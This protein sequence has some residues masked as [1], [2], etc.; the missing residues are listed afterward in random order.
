MELRRKKDAAMMRLSPLLRSITLACSLLTLGV[1]VVNAWTL[2]MDWQRTVRSTEERAI[3][4]SVAQARQAEDTFLQIEL[5][6]REVQRVIQSQPG[7]DIDVAEVNNI[8]RTLQSRLPQLEDMF[9]FD[10]QGRWT[11][12]SLTEMPK[13]N[14]NAD[15]E[16]FIFHQHNLRSSVHVGPALRSRSSGRYVIPV[17]LRINDDYGGFKGVLL[18]TISIDYFRHYYDYFVIGP[19]DLLVLMLADST[20]LYARPLP[21]SYIGKNLSSSPLFHQ[22]L[23]NAERGSGQWKAELDGEK[24]IFGFVSSSRYPVVVTAGFDTKRLFL[25]WMQSRVQGVLLSLVLLV[26]IIL[27]WIFIRNEARRSLR[28]QLELTHLRDELT[29]ANQSLK[30]LA[31]ADGLTGLA[32]RRYFDQFLKKSLLHARSSGGPV[33]LILFDID[34]FKRYNDTYGHVSGDECLQQVA[35]ILKT[36]AQ[37]RTDI[38]ARYGGEEFAIVLADTSARDA[39]TV[40]LS[41]VETVRQQAIPHVSTRLTTGCVTLSAGVAATEAGEGPEHAESLIKR[42]DDALY[43]TKHEGRN[44]ASL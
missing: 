38:A 4:L 10:S 6:L 31:N 15:R 30:S 1:I 8:M 36:F 11:A 21:D 41:V 35:Q 44:G 17:S 39:L 7:T 5:S 9:Y 22:L 26:G 37:R 14:N 25:E 33:S 42:A 23:A 34:Y 20:V 3:D 12:S 28:Y 2:H 18:A 19:Q 40:A 29:A 43:R 32:N 24:R 27:L 16:Y 13:G